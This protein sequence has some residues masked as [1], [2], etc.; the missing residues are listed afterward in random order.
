MLP[1]VQPFSLDL[2]RFKICTNEYFVLSLH[3]NLNYKCLLKNGYEQR[4]Q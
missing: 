4:K 1:L 2:K 3:P